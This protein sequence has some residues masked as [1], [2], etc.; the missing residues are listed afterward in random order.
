MSAYNYNLEE[1]IDK[2]I[3]LNIIEL[4]KNNGALYFKLPDEYFYIVSAKKGEGIVIRNFK[5]YLFAP[6]SFMVLNG[7]DSVLIKLEM[8]KKI[9]LSITVFNEHILLCPEA[10]IRIKDLPAL[11]FYDDDPVVN[12]ADDES[13][14]I[15][16]NLKKIMEEILLKQRWSWN[17]IRLYFTEILIISSRI[18]IN[19]SKNSESRYDEIIENFYNLLDENYAGHHLISF[20]TQK[21][22][23][24]ANILAKKIKAVSGKT[25]QTVVNDRIVIEAMRKLFNTNKSVK[26]IAYELGYDDPAYFHRFFKKITGNTPQDFRTYALKKYT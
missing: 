3:E 22:N 23:V 13:D 24:T 9:E 17:M 4:K 6:G 7:R 10:H 21:L 25:F 1:K 14:V 16:M 26:E 8:Q 15:N 2:S 12:P 18:I 5:E 19:N 20:Y 11:Q